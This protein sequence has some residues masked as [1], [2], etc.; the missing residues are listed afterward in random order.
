[1]FNTRA[2]RDPEALEE[3]DPTHREVFGVVF[4]TIVAVVGVVMVSMVTM[5][6]ILVI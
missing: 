2:H 5:T 1:M 4:C 6:V 3:L